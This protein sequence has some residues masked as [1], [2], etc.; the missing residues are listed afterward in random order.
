MLHQDKA[1]R[2]R[3]SARPLSQRRAC[4][5]PVLRLSF[6]WPPPAGG[7]F[8]EE[9]AASVWVKVAQ[10]KHKQQQK[11][12]NAFFLK[13]SRIGAGGGGSTPL[14]GC[15]CVMRRSVMAAWLPSGTRLTGKLTD[16][17]PMSIIYESVEI[18]S[19]FHKCCFCCCRL[20]SH[21]VF[22]HTHTHTHTGR[23]S[24]VLGEHCDDGAAGQYSCAP[25]R[26]CIWACS[27]IKTGTQNGPKLQQRVCVHAAQPWKQAQA[28]LCR[29][30]L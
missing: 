28:R 18:R 15:V 19:A 9:R 4:P 10:T 23:C 24:F 1:G 20:S 25:S 5:P 7:G 3:R 14:V 8:P 29:I 12:T 30:D 13:R 26:F 21:A 16:A 2:R 6:A 17:S 11:S 27:N 22:S